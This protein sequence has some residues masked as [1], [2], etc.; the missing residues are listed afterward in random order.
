MALFGKKN[1]KRKL[2]LVAAEEIVI[3]KHGKS[4]NR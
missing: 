1:K 3:R 2:H 4:R